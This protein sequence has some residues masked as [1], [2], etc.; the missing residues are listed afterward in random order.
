MTIKI[1]NL[2]HIYNPKAPFKKVALDNITLDIEHGDFFGIIGHTGSGKST[3]ISHLNGLIKLQSGD[4][5]VDGIDLSKRYDYK[6]LRAKVGMV[7]QYPERQLF[8]ITIERDVGF[9]PRN[10]G[11]DK[12]EI[13]KRVKEAIIK[14]G[15][16]F[17]KIKDRS[18]FEISGGQMRRAA[19][20]G[21]LA[22]KPKILILDEPTAGLDPKGKKQILHLINSLRNEVPTIIMISHNM[23]EIFENCNKIAVLKDGKLKGV[24]T[25]RELY[26][27]SSIVVDS[28]LKMP[29]V[30]QIISALKAKGYD[31]N[32]I[33]EEELIEQIIS[34]KGDTL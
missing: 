1:K 22:M 16:E 6:Q 3:L 26:D 24:F 19:L 21:V 23:D 17:E 5:T 13:D 20:A 7:F 33:N 15:L 27:N 10:L 8:D 9:G 11:L 14:V 31:L 2:S 30:Y 12:D 18:P 34:A 32:A 4:L 28:G 29:S 25:P